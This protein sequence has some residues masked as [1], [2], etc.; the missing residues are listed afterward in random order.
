M[1]ELQLKNVIPKIKRCSR[2]VCSK[3]MTWSWN[4]RI[5]SCKQQQDYLGWRWRVKQIGTPDWDP[6]QQIR[7]TMAI[8]WARSMIHTANDSYPCWTMAPIHGWLDLVFARFLPN[9]W[10]DP[11]HR[12]RSWMVVVRSCK[13]DCS[14]SRW[15]MRWRAMFPCSMRC[16][17]WYDEDRH[18]WYDCAIQRSSSDGTHTRICFL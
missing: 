18:S 16:V 14:Y 10:T 11:L 12:I 2:C 1:T 17:R 6:C 3:S 5:Q 7:E 8:R 15:S 9:D 4:R 13:L